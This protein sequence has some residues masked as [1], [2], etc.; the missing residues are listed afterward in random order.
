ML[1]IH[2]R[3]LFF[4]LPVLA[5]AQPHNPVPLKFADHSGSSLNSGDSFINIPKSGTFGVNVHALRFGGPGAA[6]DSVA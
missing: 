4:A 3:A 2:L 1:F 6:A 5:F